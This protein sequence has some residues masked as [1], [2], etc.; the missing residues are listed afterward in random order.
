MYLE[1]VCSYSALRGKMIE[2]GIIFRPRGGKNHTIYKKVP[3]EDIRNLPYDELMRKYGMSMSTIYTYK[4]RLK[5][6][7]PSS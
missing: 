3:E 2:S 6:S 4:K 1:G 7:L 5:D